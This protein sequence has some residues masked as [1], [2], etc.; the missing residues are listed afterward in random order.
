MR[1]VSFSVQNYRSIR[2][3]NKIK[4]GRSTVLVGPNNEGKSNILRALVTA[5]EVL[6]TSIGI[7][8][9]GA[10][11]TQFRALGLRRAYQWEEDYPISLQDSEPNGVSKLSLEFSLD[12]EEIEDF[13]R[14][15]KSNLN[16]LLPISLELGRERTKFSVHKKG[17]WAKA[18]S[19]K[20][21]EIAKF[22]AKRI[23]FEYIQA[24]RTAES[25]ERVVNSLIQKQL[26]AVEKLPQY[27]AALQTI[28][29]L[30]KP[31]LEAL[32]R[33][34][35]GTIVTFLPAIK[36]VT[37]EIAEQQRSLA[38]RSSA[39]TIIDDGTPTDLQH[40]GDGVQSLAAIAL[41]RH[42]S[43][44]GGPGKSYVIAIEEP[45]SHLHPRAMHVL[46]GV[47]D[48]L[49]ESYQVVITTHS[50][51]FVDRMSI[52]SNVIVDQHKAVPAKSIEEIRTVL[53]VRASDNLRNAELVLV[54]E[55]AED[56]VALAAI[57][58]SISPDLGDA[59]NSGK[60]AF[61]TLAGGTN[62]AYVLT[63]LQDV[64]LTSYHCFLDNDPTGRDSFAKAQ[65]EGLVNAGDVNFAAVPG[66]GESEIE[67]LFDSAIYKD[68]ILADYA[69]DLINNAK[70]RTN[71][72]KWSD[73]VASVFKASGKP[74]GDALEMEIKA[75]VAEIAAA[76]PDVAVYPIK[77]QVL[78]S[79]VTALLQKLKLVPTV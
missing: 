60:L 33:D 75:K 22:I 5:M 47:I 26:R 61:E 41:M 29:Q 37:F 16:G 7:Y 56:K 38:L 28:S 48:E 57:L 66:M 43:A 64:L 19:L 15:V 65:A 25:A 3:A 9:P 67:D 73:R 10:V 6:T 70:F 71:K 36:S 55:G 35:Y 18:L 78:D 2:K 52:R 72:K 49:A 51:L 27:Q 4:V 17:R 79:L 44:L 23:E 74:W 11:R 76:N 21:N 63:L 40:K 32:S 30:Q 24:V 34:V 39:R 50:A 68:R 58:R 45:E 20:A 62:L 69:V 12:P 1:L 77:K 8:G 54:V 59:I 31:V 46:R 13:R 14:E 53:G 42:A